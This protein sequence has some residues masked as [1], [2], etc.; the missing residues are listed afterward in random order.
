[1]TCPACNSKRHEDAGYASAPNLMR[2]KKCK[3]IHGSTYLGGVSSVVKNAFAP[4]DL[5]PVA[6][7]RAVHYDITCLGSQGIK[8]IHGWFDPV[9]GYVTQVG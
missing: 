9:T 4:A 2:C 6:E 7:A 5:M 8:R 1:M 3:A